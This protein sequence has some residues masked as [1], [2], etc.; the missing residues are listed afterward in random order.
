MRL[1]AVTNVV[2]AAG[3]NRV[4]NVRRD[5]PDIRDRM[6]EPALIPLKPKIDNREHVPIVLNQET[7]GSCT[8]HARNKNILEFRNTVDLLDLEAG[9]YPM[10][11]D[12]KAPGGTEQPG[13]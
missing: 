13:W 12:G 10:S 8:G 5:L 3:I 7:E 9:V 6:Y 4:L 2:H 1:K 11:S